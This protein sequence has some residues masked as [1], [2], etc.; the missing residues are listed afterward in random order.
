MKDPVC[1][2]CGNKRSVHYHEDRIYCFDHTNG[3]VFTDEPSD[4]ILVGWIEYAH[5]DTHK[6]LVNDWKH[7]NGHT[8]GEE[9]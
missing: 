8:I 7:A 6:M 5:T 4:A 1:G 2:N 3:D 9:I